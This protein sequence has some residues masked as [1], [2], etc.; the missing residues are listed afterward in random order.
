[1][2][3]ADNHPFYAAFER[4][5][6]AIGAMLNGDTRAFRQLS[7]NEDAFHAVVFHVFRDT[8]DYPAYRQ[9]GSGET[10]RDRQRRLLTQ[11][12]LE[13]PDWM[14]ALLRSPWHWERMEA[15]LADLFVYL[16]W[17][18]GPGTR[19]APEI[20]EFA[21][22]VLRREFP[23]PES[24]RETALGILFNLQ[25][26]GAWP[27]IWQALME[28]PDAAIREAVV[29]RAADFPEHR[30]PAAVAPA[31]QS[32]IERLAGAR[33]QVSVLKNAR[34]LLHRLDTAD[35]IGRP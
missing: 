33:E 35:S 26:P 28:D 19:T 2:T 22:A 14:L 7:A 11:V 32:L 27:T 10:A 9:Q 31:L 5:R 4:H 1:M 24:C 34:A 18:C 8:T 17:I 13:H 25:P 3:V 6:Y 21:L 12:A 29:M 16:E 30:P 23:C 15:E 20:G